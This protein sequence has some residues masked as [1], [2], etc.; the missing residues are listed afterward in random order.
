MDFTC[1]GRYLKV[2]LRRCPILRIS[3]VSKAV[4]VFFLGSVF[5]CAGIAEPVALA[6]NVKLGKG[7]WICY[8]DSDCACVCIKVG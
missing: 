8:C 2:L 6:C 3:T 7:V 1:E 4:R 5:L